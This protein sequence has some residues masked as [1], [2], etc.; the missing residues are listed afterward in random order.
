MLEHL[1]P[2]TAEEEPEDADEDAPSRVSIWPILES[3][4]VLTIT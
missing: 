2:I 1:M 3:S 4:R